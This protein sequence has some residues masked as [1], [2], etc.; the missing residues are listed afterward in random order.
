MLTR[1]V[2]KTMSDHNLFSRTIIKPWVFST[3]YIQTYIHTYILVTL[4]IMCILSS[5]EGEAVKAKTDTEKA[6][7]TNDAAGDAA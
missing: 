7:D 5:E 4:D 1:L 6:E 2:A 3:G